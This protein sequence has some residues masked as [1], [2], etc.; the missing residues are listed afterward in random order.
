LRGRRCRRRTFIGG[1]KDNPANLD[2]RVVYLEN[3]KTT[4]AV[5]SF[6]CDGHG[7]G[8]HEESEYEVQS[9]W[10]FQKMDSGNL[11]GRN[12]FEAV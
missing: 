8:E 2:G 10:Y 6:K 1:S 11:D 3:A 7:D 5:H 12:R 9:E 4:P